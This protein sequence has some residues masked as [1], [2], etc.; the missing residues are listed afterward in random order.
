MLR[1]TQRR[2][3]ECTV[4]L[5]LEGR[6]VAEWAPLLERETAA[7]LAEYEK[8]RLDLAHVTY[9][10]GGGREAM[11]R[12]RSRTVEITNCPPLIRQLLDMEGPA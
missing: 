5:V 9:V 4:T 1:L 3:C 11:Q 7:L 12:L 6:I 2:D 8:V 10:D